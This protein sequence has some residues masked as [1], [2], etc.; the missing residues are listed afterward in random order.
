MTDI[1]AL[2]QSLFN[3]NKNEENSAKKTH[4]VTILEKNK[5]KLKKAYTEYLKKN[6]I[7]FSVD[8]K[9]QFNENRKVWKKDT[10]YIKNWQNFTKEKNYFN[11]NFN[12]LALLTGKINNI[13]VVDLWVKYLKDNKREEPQ[14]IQAF[15][16]NGGIHLYFKWEDDFESLKNGVSLLFEG[17]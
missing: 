16:G 11:E 13:L 10:I 5:K 15:S 14:T 2:V 12:G 3:S 9:H 17:F 6:L 4:I 1:K 7:C 8:I